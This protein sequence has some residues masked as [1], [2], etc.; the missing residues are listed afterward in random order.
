MLSVTDPTVRI[1]VLKKRRESL[2]IKDLLT[3]KRS[4]K[5]RTPVENAQ[6]IHMD[7]PDEKR[8]EPLQKYNRNNQMVN[9]NFSSQNWEMKR[10]MAFVEKI[11]S[12]NRELRKLLRDRDTQLHDTRA[13]LNQI[14]VVKEEVEVVNRKLQTEIGSMRK[15]SIQ[16]DSALFTPGTKIDTSVNR[17][18]CPVPIFPPRHPKSGRRTSRK[19]N[20]DVTD[21]QWNGRYSTF[22]KADANDV[23]EL[24]EHSSCE[25]LNQIANSVPF[26]QPVGEENEMQ[27]DIPVSRR[28]R[29]FS[30][31]REHSEPF[32]TTSR[33]HDGDSVRLSE[34]FSLNRPRSVRV[35]NNNEEI[36]TTQNVV[37][38]YT[39]TN[40]ASNRQQSV[41]IRE[42]NE[43]VTSSRH[44][45][46]KTDR[47]TG[48]FSDGVEENTTIRAQVGRANH[49]E[50][51]IRN[52]PSIS[53]FNDENE[54]FTLHREQSTRIERNDPKIGRVKHEH[55]EIKRSRQQN[56][57]VSDSKRQQSGRMNNHNEEVRRI[58]PYITR[59]IDQLA[60]LTR[61]HQQSVRIDDE[62]EEIRRI[63]QQMDRINDEN[64]VGWD[65]QQSSRV[66]NEIEEAKRVRPEIDRF[67]DKNEVPLR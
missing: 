40:E 53:R 1:R 55:E 66:Q 63:R 23:A 8:R 38:R 48:R 10:N 47:Q 12:S 9:E 43:S 50:S 61:N 37:G 5:Q 16:T 46:T 6:G 60:V 33:E 21:R 28:L 36:A 13:A 2:R 20:V 41:R 25:M 54:T 7:I 62:H 35:N 19:L 22:S 3:T 24:I 44:N 42:K 27:S 45:V 65:R 15:D 18:A 4:N 58:H 57:R 34:R 11:E 29:R 32:S 14:K 49:K 52:Q 26:S 67:K 59:E 39:D 64:E 31:V 17:R 30:T 51:V 56:T